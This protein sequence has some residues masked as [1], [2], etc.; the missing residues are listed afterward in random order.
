MTASQIRRRAN[1]YDSQI[2]QGLED[3]NVRHVVKGLGADLVRNYDI[4]FSF[5]TSLC[6]VLDG[7]FGPSAAGNTGTSGCLPKALVPVSI[8]QGL[9]QDTRPPKVC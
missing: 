9:E 6:S 3:G 4:N 7:A 2:R 1:D 8:Y 5:L